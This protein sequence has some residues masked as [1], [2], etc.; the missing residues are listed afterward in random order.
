MPSLCGS[1]WAESWT[2]SAPYMG[3]IICSHDG[4]DAVELWKLKYFVEFEDGSWSDRVACTVCP[5]ADS[6]F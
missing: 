4:G 2:R 6:N 5:G 3:F 1:Y